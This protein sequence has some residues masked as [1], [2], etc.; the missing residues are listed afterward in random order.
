[1]FEKSYRQLLKFCGVPQNCGQALQCGHHRV[2]YIIYI[3]INIHAL[4]SY[5][6]V[7]FSPEIKSIL[8]INRVIIFVY[9]VDFRYWPWLL[10]DLYGC[11]RTDDSSV[12]TRRY[13]S[14]S[15]RWLENDAFSINGL[16]PRPKAR[17]WWGW[18]WCTRKTKAQISNINMNILIKMLK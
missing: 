11:S 14:N 13:V 10:V 12:F 17:N 18:P 5:F 9:Y 1:M 3:H 15:L 16:W 6:Y 4:R 8:I 7:L 2:H